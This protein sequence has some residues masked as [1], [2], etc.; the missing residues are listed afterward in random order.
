[1]VNALTISEFS[2]NNLVQQLI[3]SENNNL[4]GNQGYNDL[5]NGFV[6]PKNLIIKPNDSWYCDH[7]QNNFVCAK[8]SQLNLHESFLTIKANKITPLVNNSGNQQYFNR[9]NNVYDP[10]AVAIFNLTEANQS[11]L[12]VYST[13]LNSFTPEEQFKNKLIIPLKPSGN[14]AVGVGTN[15]IYFNLSY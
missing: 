8:F 12:Q 9:N 1:M 14:T 2:D 5:T 3:E 11:S 13:Q 10:N 6:M 7:A 4:A 15:Q